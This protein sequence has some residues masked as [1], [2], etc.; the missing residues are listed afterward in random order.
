MSATSPPSAVPPG[1][2]Y[3]LPVDGR[4]VLSPAG[5]EVTATAALDVAVVPG[6]GLP[7]TAGVA[8]PGTPGIS[9]PRTPGVS[10][11]VSPAVEREAATSRRLSR[12]GLVAVGG[13]LASGAVIAVAAAHTESLLPES[14]RPVQASLAGAFGSLF[15]NLHVGGAIA[16]LT[17]MFVSYAAVVALSGQ[18]SAR[19]VLIAIAAV[20]AF[21]LLAPPL[22]STDIFSYQAYA[23]MGAVYGTN[24]YT[25]GPYAINLDAVF[26]YV[27]AKWSYTPSAYGPVFTVFSYLLAPLTIAGSVFAYKSIAA[28]ASLALVAV[29][30]RCARLRGLDP[31]KAAA[32]V[33]LNPLLLIYGVGGGHNDLL[34]LLAMTGGVYA[35]LASRQWV[36]GGLSIVAIGIKLT[37]GLVLP[38]A[39]AA[40]GVGGAD[41]RT[42]GGR[43]R[44]A[45]GAAV[46]LAALAV[47]SFGVFGTGSFRMLG[48]VIKS[49]SEG[50][51][52]SIP[53]V[54]SAK[55]GMP[56]VGHV[57]G[58]VLAGL[59]AVALAW[60]LRRVW[61]GQT[62]WIDGAGWAM[63][64]MLVASS[65][66]LPWYV[67]WLLPLA[68]LGRNRRLAT[69]A[70]VLTGVVQGVTLL[71]YI[72]HGFL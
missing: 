7:G 71:G 6:V 33:G 20:H 35:V 61:R 63:L 46:G 9:L 60:L 72:P 44:L 4:E 45:L 3:E 52:L 51:W 22:A 69:T 11:P 8:L 16:A 28:V 27:G 58:F 49:Q 19:V 70:I 17:L 31:V 15:L 62:D 13:V 10:L 38:F 47:L 32:L 57:A 66:L 12:R 18:L 26:P 41:S 29:V 53:G 24:P 54:I 14:I 64:A 68:A 2:S 67:A 25:H 42:K 59:F 50:S 39:L 56:T 65:S 43:G 1:G 37:A 34:M 30:W 23:R 36:G 21:M 55:L 5:A 40:P 48:T